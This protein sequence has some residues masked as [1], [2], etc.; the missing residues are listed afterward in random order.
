METRWFLPNPKPEL[1]QLKMTNDKMTDDKI[2]DSFHDAFKADDQSVICY[3]SSV[4][5]D[6]TV[7][8]C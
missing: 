2:A 5:P 3:L 6:R 8:L 4:G 1:G 7:G